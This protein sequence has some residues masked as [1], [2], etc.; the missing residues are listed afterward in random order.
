ME[1]FEKCKNGHYYNKNLSSC[2]YCSSDKTQV[3]NNSD[4]KTQINSANNTNVE[5]EIDGKTQVLGGFQQNNIASGQPFNNESNRTMFVDEIMRKVE[6][7]V[8]IEQKIRSSRKLVGWLVTYSHDAMGVDYKIYEG[9][10]VIGKSM[11]CNITINDNLMT[12]KHAT[13][14]FREGMYIIKDELS[15]HGT[16]VNDIDIIDE[17][18]RLN[19]GDVIKMG[20][21]IFKFKSSL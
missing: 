12:D 9:R 5:T 15:S 18:R 7:E 1:G 4:D 14:L 3:A 6:G 2:P 21:T 17:N 8:V 20:N 13:I 19:D 11:D 10:N 16:F